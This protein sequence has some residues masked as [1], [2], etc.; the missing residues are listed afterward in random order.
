MLIVA[1]SIPMV[2][3]LLPDQRS[4]MEQYQDKWHLEARYELLSG[5]IFCTWNIVGIL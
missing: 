4:F 1:S 5:E 2:D 3:R